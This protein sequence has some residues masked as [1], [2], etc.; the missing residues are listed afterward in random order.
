M[1]NLDYDLSKIIGKTI[2][3]YKTKNKQPIS[4][5]LEKEILAIID[6]Y[7]LSFKTA[8]EFQTKYKIN[9]QVKDYLRKQIKEVDSRIE[10]D[11]DPII[12]EIIRR[13]KTSQLF[14]FSVYWSMISTHRYL[15]EE[16]MEYFQDKISWTDVS[17]NQ[18]LSSGFIEKFEDKVSWPD[19]LK[20]QKRL[21]KTLR[22]I[23]TL[24][25][26]GEC[27]SKFSRIISK[28]KL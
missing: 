9:K 22:I 8:N 15:S 25:L 24:I 13:L 14:S 12:A 3:T 10:K 5:T 21:S 1:A 7:H 6:F 26:E 23:H 27:S 18:D 20:Y 17:K 2:K 16:F 28:N 11:D 19:I 4:A